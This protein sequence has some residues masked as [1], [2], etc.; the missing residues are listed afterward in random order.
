MP[1]A[2]R[3]GP[4]PC[5]HPLGNTQ[6]LSPLSRAMF[7]LS[8]FFYIPH[9]R[10]LCLSSGSLHSVRCPEFHPQDSELQDF[11]FSY[12][13]A[14]FHR[15]C[16]PDST[17]LLLGPWLASN[18][19]YCEQC[20]CEQQSA[21]VFL[22]CHV[23]A[24]EAKK[25]NWDQKSKIVRQ[26]SRSI[27]NFLRSLHTFF[28]ISTPRGWKLLFSTLPRALAIYDVCQSHYYTVVVLL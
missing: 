5:Q 13:Q 2:P 26:Y 16:L 6:G 14:G 23:S 18:L 4:P 8:M 9:E 24:L 10:L 12:S 7:F 19:K 15:A 27:L 1:L 22:K 25:W 17:P 28:H 3:P 11:I 21:D 20:C